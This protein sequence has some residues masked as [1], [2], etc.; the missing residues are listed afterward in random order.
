MWLDWCMGILF[1]L[2]IAGAAY[3]KK[4]LSGS[5]AVAAVV[6]G[7]VLFAWGGLPW[8]GTLL[9]FFLTSTFLT[10]WRHR[11][12]A[13]VES[14]YAKS[15][16]RDAGQVLANGGLGTLLCIGH[17][18]WP[19]PLWWAAFIGVMATVTADTWAT[20]IG[21]SSRQMPR[22]IINGRR[23]PAGTS[24]GITALGLGASLSGGLVIGIFGWLFIQWGTDAAAVGFNTYAS[25][26]IGLLL[27]LG[28]VG[29][30]VG[31]LADSWLGAVFQVM[32]RC[33]VCGKEVEK[34][35]HCNVQSVQVRGA[36]F[37]TND[38][39]NLISSL[40]GGAVC[41]GLYSAII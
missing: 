13:A 23:V 7:T 12:K 28:A 14:G 19:H 22:S 4:S 31:S 26:G 5:G 37:M 6:V 41:V 21:G 24:G 15:G 38:A 35:R 36:A 32:Y 1:S 39:V 30:M 10:K 27:L 18:L 3:G 33:A 25:S 20:E 34:N 8:Y 40:L 2:L 17:S 11:Q 29:G 16:R 9:V